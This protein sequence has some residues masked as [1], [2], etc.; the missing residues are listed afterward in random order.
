MSGAR[1]AFRRESNTAGYA[2]SSPAA[3][4]SVS[5]SLAGSVESAASAASS[6]ISGAASTVGSASE[7]ASMGSV[8]VSVGSADSLDF[9]ARFLGGA[10][11]ALLIFLTSSP[12]PKPG[13]LRY[14][15]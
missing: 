1:K 7:V 8:A 15:R 5:A 14:Y 13:A 2:L 9:A 6:A 4:L 10:A 11:F 3:A 12:W